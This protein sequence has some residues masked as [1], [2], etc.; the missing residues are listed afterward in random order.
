M[1]DTVCEYLKKSVQFYPKEK[2]DKEREHS[3]NFNI[4][5]TGRAHVERMAPSA[6]ERFGLAISH[7]FSAEWGG[8]GGNFSFLRLE[9][10]VIAT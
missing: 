10:T 8:G 5:S 6:E 2:K 4:P 9:T 1:S 7:T 3:V